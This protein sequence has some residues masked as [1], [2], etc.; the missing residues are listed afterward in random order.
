MSNT[1]SAKYKEQAA[2][3]VLAGKSVV[4]VARALFINVYPLYTWKF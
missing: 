3:R 4:K 2:K 1:Y